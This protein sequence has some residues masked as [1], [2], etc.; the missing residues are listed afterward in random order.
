MQRRINLRFS[1]DLILSKIF[2][3]LRVVKK[4]PSG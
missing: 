3:Y 1:R 2:V 4:N